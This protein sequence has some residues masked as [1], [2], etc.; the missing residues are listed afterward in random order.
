MAKKSAPVAQVLWT[1]EAV[2]L[3][4]VSDG[5]KVRHVAEMESHRDAAGNIVWQPMPT[6]APVQSFLD[7]FGASFK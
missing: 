7:A 2:R 5:A 6:S 1:G 3:V 4:R